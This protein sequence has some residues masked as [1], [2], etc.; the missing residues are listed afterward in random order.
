[1]DKFKYLEPI[2]QMLPPA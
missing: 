1:M 2:T